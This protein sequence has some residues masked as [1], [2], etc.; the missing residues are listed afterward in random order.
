[1]LKE[2]YHSIK[3]ETMTDKTFTN[4]IVSALKRGNVNTFKDL[5]DF[6]NNKDAKIRGIGETRKRIIYEFYT[7][8]ISQPILTEIDT[9]YYVGIT[10]DEDYKHTAVLTN[11]CCNLERVLIRYIDNDRICYKEAS[12]SWI[13]ENKWCEMCEDYHIDNYQIMALLNIF[14]NDVE[15]E[16][17]LSDKLED[18]DVIILN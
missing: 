5:E 15:V 6:I 1:M 10:C 18:L 2:K 4:A 11:Y 17:D 14:G 8:F 13:G 3:L 9:E 12:I 16:V 7:D